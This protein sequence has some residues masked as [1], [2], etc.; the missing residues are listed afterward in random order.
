MFPAMAPLWRPGG[1]A[2]QAYDQLDPVNQRFIPNM[3]DES[4]GWGVWLSFYQNVPPQVEFFS[5]AADTTEE[6]WF[7]LLYVNNTVTQPT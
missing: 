4:L 7:D 6:G 5:T 3:S 2:V 1:V